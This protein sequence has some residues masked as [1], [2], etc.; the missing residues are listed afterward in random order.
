MD[1]KWK[2]DEWKKDE[3]KKDEWKKDV[4]KRRIETFNDTK[5]L[6]GNLLF[7]RKSIMDSMA[8]QKLFKEGESYGFSKTHDT[9][10]DAE[11]IVSGKRSLEAAM[12]YARQGK[13]VCVLNFASATNPGGA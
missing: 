8:G 1:N 2:K 6:Y 5:K 11:V 4:R 3:W 12:T 13:K 9:A 10:Q 7:L